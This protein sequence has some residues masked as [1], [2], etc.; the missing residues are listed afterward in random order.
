LSTLRSELSALPHTYPP[1]AAQAANSALSTI[2]DVISALDIVQEAFNDFQ[3][4]SNA[5]QL[6]ALRNKLTSF[7][8]AFIK[9]KIGISLI[10]AFVAVKVAAIIGGGGG[11][12]SSSTVNSTLTEAPPPTK[13]TQSSSSS[14]STETGT[15]TPLLIIPIVGGS[16]SDEQSLASQ[17]KQDVGADNVMTFTKPDNHVAMWRAPLDL[18][19]L[20]KYKSFPIVSI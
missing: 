5:A 18:R 10:V 20:A 16:L 8:Q 13:A 4:L 7:V 17:L 11:D 3:K 15:P 9:S 19:L 2:P 14:T 1:A 12:S 6:L